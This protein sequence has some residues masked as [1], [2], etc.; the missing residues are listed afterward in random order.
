M[1]KVIKIL[2]I[3]ILIIFIICG[4]SFAIINKW[5]NNNLKVVETTENAK[6]IEIE[7][8]KGTRTEEIAE[9]LE[10]NKIIRDALAFKIYMKLNNI[11]NI[12]AGKY[13]FDK[14]LT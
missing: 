13:E 11:T 7:I 9:I 6:V 3:I 1:K 12:Q 8:K 4:I 2:L 14:L 10:E 5:Y